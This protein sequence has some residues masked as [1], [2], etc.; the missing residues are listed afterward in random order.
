MDPADSTGLGQLDEPVRTSYVL[1]AKELSAVNGRPGTN[2]QTRM[3]QMQNDHIASSADR[4]GLGMMRIDSLDAQEIRELYSSAREL[5]ITLF[6]HADIYGSEWHD[7][8]GRFGDAIK[9]PSSEREEIFLQTKCGIRIDVPGLDCSTEYIVRQAEGSLRALGTDYLD[10][11][12]LHRPDTLVEPEEVARAFD[13]LESSGKVRAFGVSNHTGGQLDLLRNSIKQPLVTNQVQFGLGHA[14]LVAQGLAANMEDT[15]QSINLDGSLL[16]YS[17]IHGITLQAW[18]PFQNG[19]FKG[20]I[21]DHPELGELQKVLARIAE[22]YGTTPTAIA[23]AWV[24]RHPA[25][26]QVILGTTR[27]HRVAESVTGA[28]ITLSRAEW[29][30]LYQAAGYIVP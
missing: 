18:S 4:I 30:E 8:E 26:M 15:P 1:P 27:T 5:G 10:M 13:Q 20:S 23:T 22:V 16:D 14:A 3:E 29:Y 6:D 21:F 17:R 7:C 2:K 28:G 12:M 24:T 19:F 9:L 25:R 11:L